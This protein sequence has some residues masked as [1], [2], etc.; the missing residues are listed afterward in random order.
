MFKSVIVRLSSH[1]Q[2]MSSYGFVLSR[3]RVQGC[4][5]HLTDETRIATLIRQYLV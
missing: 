4:R 5:I 3:L 2:N 1:G